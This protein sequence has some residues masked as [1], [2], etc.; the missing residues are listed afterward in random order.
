M[1]LNVNDSNFACDIFRVY[2]MY[3]MHCLLKRLK[4]LV[5]FLYSVCLFVARC[6]QRIK[7]HA[8][9]FHL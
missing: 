1:I 2:V 6:H 3:C 4:D 9:H 7:R 8:M 5:R